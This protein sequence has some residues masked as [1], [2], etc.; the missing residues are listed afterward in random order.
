MDAGVP[1]VPGAQVGS[2]A[3]L[4]KAAEAIGFPVMLKA[5]AGG[6]GKGMRL[7][8]RAG[9]LADAFDRARSEAKSAFGDDTVYLEKALIRPRH[10][11][12]Q[13]LADQHGNC[14]HLFERDCSIQRRHQKVVEETPSPAVHATDALVAE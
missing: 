2:A 14:V 6:G 10:V 4:G 7:V 8:E 9:D 5:A 3:E 13:V 1:V 12:I 11:E